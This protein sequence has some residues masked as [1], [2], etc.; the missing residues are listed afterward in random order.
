MSG[1]RTMT[2][3]ELVLRYRAGRWRWLLLSWFIGLWIFALLLQEV[4]WRSDSIEGHSGT[5]LFGGLQLFM[6]GLALFIVPALT[7][8]SVNG[9]RERGRLGVLQVTELSP[10]DI[11]LGKLFAS[12]GVACLFV[13]V[14]A[15]ITVWAV[16]EGGITWWQVI[17]V[18][19]VMLLLL[20]IFCAIGLGLSSLFARSTTSSVL[21]YVAVFVLALGTVIAAGL[22][23]ALDSQS[24]NGP[25]SRPWYLMAPNPFVILADAAPAAPVKRTCFHIPA[26]SSGFGTSSTGVIGHS[27]GSTFCQISTVPGDVL[28]G[29]RRGIRSME[30]STP[31][32]G[33]VGPSEGG[34]VWPYGLAFDLLLSGA[35]IWVA[36][37]RVG[38]PIRHLPKGVRVA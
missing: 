35:L 18:T 38:T 34:P 11:I 10:S 32:N 24:S 13:L 28:G 22:V 19:L 33:I 5:V 25:I 6:L 3:L 2:K 15:P 30:T 16:V 26:P 9:D 7:S 31:G 27:S 29:I 1:I 8:Q 20:G 14:S 12:W 37:R 4:V 21:T 23:S 17:A 36:I